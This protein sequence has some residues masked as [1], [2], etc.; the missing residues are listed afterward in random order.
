MTR[1]RSVLAVLLPALVAFPL[2]LASGGCANTS[3]DGNTTPTEK[4]KPDGEQKPK[5][6]HE[7]A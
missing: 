4:S 6:Q 1:I 7:P 5:P 2:L 3:K